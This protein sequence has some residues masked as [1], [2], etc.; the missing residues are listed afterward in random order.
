MKIELPLNWKDLRLGELQAYMTATTDLDRL[1]AL[2]NVPRETLEKIPAGDI[3]K[4]Y[5]HMAKLMSSETYKFE[6]ILLIDGVRYGII[7]DWREFSLG[8]WIDAN[9]YLADLWPNAHKLMAL[10]Y[11]PVKWE[12]RGN[13]GIEAYTAKENPEPFKNLSAEHLSGAVLFFWAIGTKQ[14]TDSRWS[15]M[16]GRLT[17]FWGNGGGITRCTNWLKK[18]FYKSNQSPD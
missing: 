3:R 1:T 11:R 10:L 8:E 13:Y 2:T 18:T 14:P 5:K 15:S 9:E 17:S 6:P 4:A 16:A 7:P 12:L